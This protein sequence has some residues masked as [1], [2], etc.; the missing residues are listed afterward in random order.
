M[1]HLVRSPVFSA[2]LILAAAGI[3]VLEAADVLRGPYLQSAAADRMTV[4]WRTDVDTT[5]ELSYGLSPDALPP[6]VVEPG[7]RTEHA[8][9]LTGLL[10]AT[11]YYYRVQG[12]PAAGSPVNVGGSGQWFKTAPAPGSRAPVRIWVVGD[13]GYN[14]PAAVNSLNAYLNATALQAKSTDLFMMLG[15]NAYVEGTDSQYQYSVFNRY[16]PLLQNTPVWSAFGNHDSY[17]STHLDSLGNRDYLGPVPYDSI[18]H[19][20]SGGECGGVP[21]GSERYY[22]FNH[23]NVHFICLDTNTPG[24]CDDVPGGTPGMVDWLEADLSSCSADWI[25]AFMHQGPYTK[26]QSHDSDVDWDMRR[27]RDYVVPILESYGTDLVLCGHSHVYERSGL[28]DGHYGMSST[29]N[30]ATM[31]KWPGNGSDLG[32]VDAA[33]AFV[34]G[35]GLAGGAYQKAAA[36]ARSGTVY[37]VVGASSLAHL[38]VNGSSATVNPAPHP[39]HQVSLLVTGSMVIDID[40]NKLHA[41]YLDDTGAVRDDFTL[42]KG[43]KYQLHRAQP[44]FATQ[45]APG[46]SFGISRSGATAL[47]D[48]IAFSTAPVS[49]GTVTPA[50]GTVAFPAGTTE[51]AVVFS[52]ASGQPGANFQM[53]LQTATRAL[54]PGSAQRAIYQIAGPAAREGMIAATPA[55]TWYASRFGSLPASPAVWM[56][57]PYLDGMNLLMEYATGAEPGAADPAPSAR[58]EGNSWIYRYWRA[59]GRSDLNLESMVSDNLSTWQAAGALDTADGPPALRGEPRRVTLPLTPPAK[60]LRLKATLP[61]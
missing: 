58:V 36:T 25:I 55:A 26:G 43:S 34:P 17:S 53:Q 3:S 14:S 57:D 48:G 19:F 27:T 10:P 32:G 11:R 60:F 29:W 23:G 41:Q 44:S 12:T 50:Q 24:N 1:T 52:P 16:A 38:W 20:P 6:P 13:A 7:T 33:G 56:D 39:A 35:L 9:T 61:P 37:S 49:G 18:F 5:S 45:S 42:L 40:G 54:Q 31:R 21:S 8:I 47:A 51:S 59:A 15:D 4:C 2:A 30:E 46:L 22:S 28:I